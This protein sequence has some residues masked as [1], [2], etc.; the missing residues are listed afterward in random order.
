M[1][2]VGREIRQENGCTFVRKGDNL[3]P[4]TRRAPV[5]LNYIALL[6]ITA[7]LYNNGRI[8]GPFHISA[9]FRHQVNG[10]VYISPGDD[11]A[12]KDEFQAILQ[13][14]TYHEQ[15]R[16]V[17][18][19]DIPSESDFTAFKSWI[20]LNFKWRETVILHIRD[21]STDGAQSVHKDC[22]RSLFHTWRSSDDMFTFRNRKKGSRKAHSCPSRPDVHR[23]RLT[24]KP[25]NHDIGIVAVRHVE[26]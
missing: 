10:H 23:M 1:K 20:T 19:A 5:R 25:L 17:L 2:T 13:I 12:C 26:R 24:G 11:I 4:I 8:I 21:I 22:D 14:G 7:G 16:D 3:I 9:E 6:V 18:R 15:R